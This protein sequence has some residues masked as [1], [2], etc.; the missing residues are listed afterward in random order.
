M[1]LAK[2]AMLQLLVNSRISAMRKRPICQDTGVAHV[3]VEIGMEVRFATRAGGAPPSLRLPT[4]TCDGDGSDTNPL[5]A[6][7]V[8]SPLGA[9]R[10]TRDNTPGIVHVEMMAGSTVAVTVVAKGGGGDVKARFATLNPSDRPL[11]GSW[12]SYRAWEPAGAAGRAWHRDRREPRAGDAAGKKI[13]L[14][15]ATAECAGGG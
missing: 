3:F 13:P 1:A 2:N 14:Q 7:M 12:N 4:E 9:R 5:R 11:T 15:W 8:S 10:N 6:S